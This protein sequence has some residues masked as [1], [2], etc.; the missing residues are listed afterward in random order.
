MDAAPHRQR[1]AAGGRDSVDT[2]FSFL[3]LRHGSRW[4]GGQQ[5]PGRL[6]F[7]TVKWLSGLRGPRNLHCLHPYPG[8]C[9]PAP[10]GSALCPALYGAKRIG[11]SAY[12]FLPMGEQRA[13]RRAGP[14]EWV[15]E[16][17]NPGQIIAL[18]INL[19]TAIILSADHAKLYSSAIQTIFH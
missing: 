4:G 17:S 5:A 2:L 18:L 19:K 10:N 3:V 15:L 11:G 1:R 8:D 12:A 9:N 7:V 14:R 13:K 16:W 6:G